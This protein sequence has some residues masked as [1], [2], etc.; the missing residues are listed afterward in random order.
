MIAS[1]SSS[2]GV[3][4]LAGRVLE[5]QGLLGMMLVLLLFMFWSMVWRVWSGTLKA[6]DAEIKRLVEERNRYQSL[7]FERLLSSHP[8]PP[9]GSE[10]PKP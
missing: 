4:G 3:W 7:V 1:S 9:K 6:K 5:S 8:N 2:T 10:E